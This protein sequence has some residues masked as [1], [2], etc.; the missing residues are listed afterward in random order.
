[1]PCEIK[2]ASGVKKA[3]D[4]KCYGAVLR[5]YNE[6]R[7]TGAP[8]SI[9]REAAL[10]VYVYHHPEDRIDNAKLTVESWVYSQ[11]TH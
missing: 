7:G 4:C 10:R 8:D 9:A 11:T 6:M 5:T 3:S 1:M 2:L